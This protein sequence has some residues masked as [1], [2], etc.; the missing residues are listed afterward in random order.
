VAELSDEMRKAAWSEVGKYLKQF[1]N[2]AGWKT[3]LEVIVA[4]GAASK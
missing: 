1:E 4:S 2:E 3:E